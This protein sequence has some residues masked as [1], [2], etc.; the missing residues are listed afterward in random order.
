MKS[1]GC[2][3]IA[4]WFYLAISS[5]SLNFLSS[6]IKIFW[7]F[8][9]LSLNFLSYLLLKSFK[10]VFFSFCPWSALGTPTPWVSSC[11]WEVQKPQ[12]CTVKIGVRR[13][14]PQIVSEL[15][16]A[17]SVEGWGFHREAKPIPPIPPKEYSTPAQFW[18][19]LFRFQLQIARAMRKPTKQQLKATQIHKVN[20]Q[21]DTKGTSLYISPFISLATTFHSK[22]PQISSQDQRSFHVF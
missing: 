2:F 5:K 7:K 9:F 15:S 11:A 12:S 19:K 14:F 4:W 1:L 20:S 22:F 10:H 21:R 13:R 8:N 6:K 17:Q 18:R 3:L 16:K